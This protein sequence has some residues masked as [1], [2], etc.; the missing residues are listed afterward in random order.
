MEV[1]S[2]QRSETDRGT[3]FHARNS[4]KLH[5]ASTRERENCESRTRDL[6]YEYAL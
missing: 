6:S 5:L 1:S 4:R 2:R 3:L